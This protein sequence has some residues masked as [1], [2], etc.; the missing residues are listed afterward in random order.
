MLEACPR[1][2][3]IALLA[4]RLVAEVPVSSSHQERAIET[5]KIALFTMQSAY[6]AQ[7]HDHEE[8]GAQVSE[9]NSGDRED[10]AGN[11]GTR[12][13]CTPA[14]G[15]DSQPAPTLQEASGYHSDQD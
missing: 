13:N 1:V 14:H 2:W 12:G 8:T 7:D 5:N 10:R 9:A 11:A 6:E 3:E 4:S 15:Q